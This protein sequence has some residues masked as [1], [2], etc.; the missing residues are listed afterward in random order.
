[1]PG[2][3]PETR[4]PLAYLY[5]GIAR[6]KGGILGIDFFVYF[7]LSIKKEAS[8]IF[9]VTQMHFTVPESAYA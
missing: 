9:D 3:S 1:M 5:F 8:F 4:P 7:S 2:S 6:P